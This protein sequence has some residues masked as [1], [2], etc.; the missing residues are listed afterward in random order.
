MTAAKTLG[1]RFRIEERIGEGGMGVVYRAFDCKKECLVAVKA[2]KGE[3]DSASIERFRTEWRVLADL[4]HPNIVDVLDVGTFFDDGHLRPYFVMPLL[5]GC[6]LDKLITNASPPL[7]SER[8]IDIISQTCRGLQA[9]HDHGLVHCDLK[10]SN[11][12]VLS[13]DAV[14]IIDFGIVRLVDAESRIDVRGTPHYMAPEQLDMR[15]PSA[16]SDIFSLAVVCYEALTRQKPFGGSTLE[17]VVEAIRTRIPPPAWQLNPTTNDNVSKT[18]Q[19]AMAKQPY[20]RFSS[21]REFSEM[22]Q[23]SM[24]NPAKELFPQDK[25]QSR[26]NRIKKALDEGDCQ[27]A[28]DILDELESEG[29][30]N[31][32]IFV[33]RDKT[34]GALRSRAIHQFIE[35][36]RS[37]MEE[38]EYPG[39]MQ[40]VRRAL[41]LDPANV[42]AQTIKKE[43]EQRKSA[44]QVEKWLQTAQRHFDNKAFEKAR[45]AIAEIR[46]A[47]PNHKSAMDLLTAIG[48]D[49][50]ELNTLRQE[51]QQLYDEARMAYRNGE[52]GAAFGKLER[53]LNLGRGASG[54]AGMDAQYLRFYEELR[55]EHDEFLNS[56]AEG[57]RALESHNFARAYE[58]CNEILRR[59]PH[60]ALFEALK[61]EV[62]ATDRQEKFATIAQLHME[63]A[64][65]P[66][67]EKQFA[68]VSDAV[69]HFPDEQI[70][71]HSLKLIDERRELVNSLAARARHYEMQSLFVEARNEW[72]TIRTVYAQYPG[73]D[74]ELQRLFRKQEY[75]REEAKAARI[76]QVD[77]ARSAGEYADAEDLI[78]EAL[79][80]FPKDGELIRLKKQVREFAQRSVEAQSLLAKEQGRP[81]APL[82]WADRDVRE[83]QNEFRLSQSKNTLLNSGDALLNKGD[84]QYTGPVL[85]RP[86][87]PAQSGESLANPGEPQSACEPGIKCSIVG[88]PRRS[89]GSNLEARAI[90]PPRLPFHPSLRLGPVTVFPVP[91][92]LFATVAVLGLLSVG[93]L[94]IWRS[95]ANSATGNLSPVAV[96]RIGD[97][98]GAA[99]SAMSSQTTASD[100]LRVVVARERDKNSTS[101]PFHV[102]SLPRGRV[103][104][105]SHPLLACNTPCELPLPR[106]EQI[107]QISAPGYNSVRRAVKVPLEQSVFQ[108]LTAELKAVRICSDPTEADL[109]VDHEKKGRTPITLELSVGPHRIRLTKTDKTIEKVINVTQYDLWFNISLAAATSRADPNDPSVPK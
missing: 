52:I 40:N 101:I 49:E 91:P 43:I 104:T 55:L 105:I 75:G 48:R 106:G 63:I 88:Q 69:R 58:I 3:M 80:E 77:W 24:R 64:A 60:E 32:D 22:L 53:V 57:K 25:I 47:D 28:M 46:K 5:R 51:R 85:V 65:E 36:A 61:N 41:D 33:L 99:R 92:R 70:F 103:S 11:L 42:D 21:A 97:T 20:H 16:R 102:E 79:H 96:E 68:I 44:S 13:D 83:Y 59:R 98:A 71:A 19:K 4:N 90:V 45:Y 34:E 35:S 107:L 66:D 84:D 86:R 23:L 62:E 72:N 27:L 81:E 82:A 14:K 100:P 2:L 67:L 17:E 12:F 8:I 109:T 89:L 7:T 38:T 15:P 50:D 56:Y 31:A 54:H 26:I 87:G 76:N 1:D 78:E 95:R 74:S 73:L 37:R 108:I 9:A 93:L 94:F 6:T 30:L 10:P 39:A 29:H 18:V